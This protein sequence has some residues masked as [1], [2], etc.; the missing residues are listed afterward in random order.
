MMHPTTITATD[1]QARADAAC[2]HHEDLSM[3]AAH[4]ELAC[5]LAHE[6]MVGAY[7]AAEVARVAAVSAN[8]D[9][10]RARKAARKAAR[11]AAA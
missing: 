8:T 4:A 9:A 10:R 1:A 5:C 2:Q 6:V 11:I 7:A 3:L